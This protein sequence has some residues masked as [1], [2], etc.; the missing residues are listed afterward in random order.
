MKTGAVIPG[1]DNSRASAT[2]VEASSDPTARAS[3]RSSLPRLQRSAA[4][5]R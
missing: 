1:G 4:R 3:Y 5:G 2:A